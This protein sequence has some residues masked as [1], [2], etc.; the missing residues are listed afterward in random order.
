MDNTV[1][2]L[3]VHTYSVSILNS[4][5][6]TVI[7]FHI[8]KYMPYFLIDDC[9][10]SLIYKSIVITMLFIL[11]TVSSIIYD[12]PYIAGPQSDLS[13]LMSSSLEC[14]LTNLLDN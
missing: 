12:K 13:S 3:Y 10:L 6:T 7:H 2:I 1:L 4:L 11:L 14:I 9:K 5:K 8:V